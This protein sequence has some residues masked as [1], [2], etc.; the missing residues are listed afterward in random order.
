MNSIK[1]SVIIPVYNTAEYLSEAI[2]S[3]LQQSLQEIEIIAINDGSEDD[4]LQILKK[5][6]LTDSRI[7]VISFEKNVGVRWRWCLAPRR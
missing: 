1:V 7:K 3:I 5:L 6:S 4:S 2:N